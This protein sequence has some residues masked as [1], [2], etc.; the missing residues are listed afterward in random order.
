MTF[1]TS[2]AITEKKSTFQT[3][4]KGKAGRELPESSSSEFSKKIS[5]NN[6]DLLHR[7]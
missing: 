6:F 1:L 5:P 2:L 3:Y 7:S 4:L